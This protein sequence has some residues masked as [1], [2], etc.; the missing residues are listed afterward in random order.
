MLMDFNMACIDYKPFKVRLIDENLKKVLPY[1]FIAP[2]AKTA[3]RVLPI[4]II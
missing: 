1:A 2:T 4:A 3:V